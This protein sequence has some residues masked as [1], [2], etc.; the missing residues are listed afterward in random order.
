MKIT[1]LAAWGVTCEMMEA[2]ITPAMY[3]VQVSSP[4]QML[5]GTRQGSPESGVLFLIGVWQGMKKLVQRWRE[6]QRGFR[7]GKEFLSHLI[8]VVDLIVIASDPFQ[9]REMM[10]QLRAALSTVGLRIN[11]EKTEYIASMEVPK[12]LLEGV[13]AT[14]TGIRILGRKIRPDNKH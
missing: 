6:E 13:D 10:G 2:C 1:P 3:G 5:R 7:V 14:K 9:A 11:G 8:F 12:G 4:I